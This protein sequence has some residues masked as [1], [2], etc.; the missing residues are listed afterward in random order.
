MVSE[1]K[2]ENKKRKFSTLTL[3]NLF[4]LIELSLIG[5]LL[6]RTSHLDIA[7]DKCKETREKMH[8]LELELGGVEH[9]STACLELIDELQDSL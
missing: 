4:C 1:G 3:L 9:N 8:R 2:N 7:V 6:K 5:H